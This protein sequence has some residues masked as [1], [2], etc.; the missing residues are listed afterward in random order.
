[1]GG[2]EFMKRSNG[3]LGRGGLIAL[4]LALGCAV[5]WAAD[6]LVVIEQEAA[7]RRDKKTYSP[8]VAKLK[9]GDKV[10]LLDTQSP[11]L[12]VEFQGVQGWINESSVSEK[13][14]RLSR[15]QTAQGVVA[16]EQSAAGRGFNPEVEKKYREAKPDLKPFYDA[17]DAIEKVVVPDE[18]ILR[19]MEEGKL[20]GAA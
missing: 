9:E 2:Q 1:M 12:R 5:A 8:R 6:Q 20:G 17:I 18:A 7:I 11:W 13:E 16:T 3:G 19:F 10:T 14:V 4:A 15:D